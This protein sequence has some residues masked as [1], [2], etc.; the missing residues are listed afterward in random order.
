MRIF[1]AVQ[2]LST[3]LFIAWLL[4]VWVKDSKFGS[5]PECNHLVKYV[6]FFVNVRATETWLRILFITYLALN[7]SMM[8]LTFGT[9]FMEYLH[10]G[11][12][13]R[14]QD[15]VAR[16]GPE[17]AEQGS[18]REGTTPKRVRVYLSVM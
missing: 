10:K 16:P 9:I 4:Y 6:L 13:Q 5:Q 3:L 18:A 8:L 7:S 1:I 17:P 12:H 14:L 15:V 11:I 2:T